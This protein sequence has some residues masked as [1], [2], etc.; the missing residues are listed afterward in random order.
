VKHRI[1]AAGGLGCASS[2]A[3]GNAL[4][5]DR[6]ERMLTHR[7]PARAPRRRDRVARAE[8]DLAVA[9]S[10]CPAS[11]CNGG[12]PPRPLACEVSSGG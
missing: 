3:T 8:M 12:E 1:P 7:R 2:A 4:W 6:R 5:S 11:S 10:A 9:I